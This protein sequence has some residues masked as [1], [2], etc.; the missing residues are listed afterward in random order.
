MRKSF[1]PRLINPP[2]GDPGVFI[3]FAL[4][5]R[6]ILFDMGDIYSL[7]P[8]DILKITH[9][10]ISH[11]HMDHFS[12]F[13]HMLRLLLG[14]EKEIRIY[15]PKGIIEN[16]EGKLKGYSWN[17]VQGYK[18]SLILSVTEVREQ[19]LISMTFR[20]KDKF[21]P[22]KPA[23]ILPFSDILLNEPVFEVSTAILD[24]GIPC[25]GFAL[26]E[27]FH[28][29]IKK[30]MLTQMGFVT[31]PWLAEF[32]RAILEGVSSEFI[33]SVPMLSGRNVRFRLGDL[34]KKIAFI[35]PGEKIVYI[36]DVIFSPLNQ[37]KIISL[38]KHATHLFIEASFLDNDRKMAFNKFHL[39]AKEAGFLAGM[40][41]VGKFT[42]FH[43]SPRYA[44]ME[45][46]FYQEA[47]KAYENAVK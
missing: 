9:I 15:G 36:T 24:H 39:T 33:F 45:E 31:G 5:K 43:F 1:S 21:I 3:P 23:E 20:C 26:K 42:L 13:D 44:H 29:N 25:L 32:K 17:L 6:A 16:V 14:R 41:R 7:S 47:Q 27:K 35:S 11:T 4:E 34:K 19:K 37:K 8:K 22:R 38:A 18:E 12:G 2:Q 40:A 30:D 10:F 46:K 28:I